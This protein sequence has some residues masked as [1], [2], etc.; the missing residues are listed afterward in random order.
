MIQFLLRLHWFCIVK[1][2]TTSLHLVHSLEPLNAVTIQHSSVTPFTEHIAE[3]FTSHACSGILDLYVGYDEHTRLY[4]LSDTLRSTSSYKIT[5]G[6]DEC[7]SHI[8]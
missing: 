4:N 3:Q 2:D 5:D 7:G 8:S 1:K 6:M